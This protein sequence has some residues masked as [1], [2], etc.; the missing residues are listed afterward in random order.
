MEE[1]TPL[2][3][4]DELRGFGVIMQACAEAFLNEPSDGVVGD[5][6]R[7]AE[8]LGDD[9]FSGIEP[10]ADLRQRY[11]DRLFV[12][13]SPVYVPLLEGSVRGAA[14]E[15]GR[16]RYGATSSSQADHVLACYRA[17]GFDYRALE[18]Y[19]SAVKALKPDSLAAELAFLAF[20]AGA[21]ADAE[22]D[23]AAA[24][25]AFELLAQFAR[26]HA[27]RWFSKAAACLAAGDDDLYAR[28]AALAAEA[29]EAAVPLD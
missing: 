28:A 12:P 16:M 24:Q 4:P 6:Q 15:D 27:A 2:P 5:L 13:T 9:R 18:G 14:E 25:R 22:G 3:S 11:Y 21:A 8:A 10:G 26:E 1:A 23:A 19:E 29:L 20:L 17:V 7:V